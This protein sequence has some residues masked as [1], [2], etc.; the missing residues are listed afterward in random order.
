MPEVEGIADGQVERY[1][2]RVERETGVGEGFLVRKRANG[3]DG[4]GVL[5]GLEEARG[6]RRGR[7]KRDREA[8]YD[9]EG[10]GDGKGERN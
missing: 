2:V 10:R 1:E 3:E 8:S 5:V 6:K 9:G 4:V 7:G